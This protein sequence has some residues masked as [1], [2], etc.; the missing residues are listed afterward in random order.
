M[1]TTAEQLKMRNRSPQYDSY[2]KNKTWMN[3][4]KSIPFQS[5]PSA[6]EWAGFG[7]YSTTPTGINAPW[8]KD[9]AQTLKEGQGYRTG[10][11]LAAEA[12]GPTTKGLTSAS[13]PPS[14]VGFD[15]ATGAFDPT[16]M[17]DTPVVTGM[18]TTYSDLG[19]TPEALAPAT[20]TSPNFVNTLATPEMG[21]TVGMD[22][23]SGTKWLGPDSIAADT[24]QVLGL[25]GEG[26]QLYSGLQDL[27]LF[28]GTST[29]DFR[30]QQMKGMKEN[31]ANV[32]E[33]MADRRKFR[34]GLASAYA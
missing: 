2:L 26:V 24:S 9:I 31:L 6:A 14:A 1:A 12:Y 21:P 17:I 13:V 29:Q 4:S 25:A 30:G 10:T 7:D 3:Q 5:D 8:N 11:G 22:P 32:R 15:P 19:I 16:S 23:G 33:Q 27:G 28:G 20:V 34:G 18:D